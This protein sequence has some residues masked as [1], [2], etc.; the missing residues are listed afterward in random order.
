MKTAYIGGILLDGTKDMVP[1]KGKTVIVENGRITAILSAEELVPSG[2]EIVNLKGCYL[3]PGLINLHVH[4]NSGG[5]PSG[6]KKEPGDYVRLVNLATSNAITGEAVRALMRG[7]ANTALHSGVTT[8]RTVGGISD[9]DGRLRNEIEEGYRGRVKAWKSEEATG[10]NEFA[11]MVRKAR[12][13]MSR[14]PMGAAAPEGL[15]ALVRG[16][17]AGAAMAGPRILTSNTGISVPGGHVAGSLAYPVT[18]PEEA[19]K[20]V[21]K[22]AAG[23]PDL[24]KL[25]ITGGIMDAEKEGEPGVLKMSPEIIEAACKAAH[26][27]KLPVAAHAESTEGVIA[28]LRGGVDTIE[29]G[30]KLT[31]ETIRL[32]KERN[33]VDICTLSP[34]IPYAMFT[35]EESHATEVAK[36]NGKVVL[37]GMIDC[38]KT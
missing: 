11:D 25:M 26:D 19:V 20:Y 4:L 14:I 2:C 6:R 13:G 5:K 30:A 9:Y 28:G 10:K 27:L 7:Y 29:H 3:M 16:S 24:I 1:Q 35:L 34:A 31:D 17:A 8:I 36:N 33:A 15:G 21:H 37:A 18:S 22:I 23:R 32:F 38:A 12:T